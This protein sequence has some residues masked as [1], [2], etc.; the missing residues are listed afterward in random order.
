[1]NIK[2]YVGKSIWLRPTGNNAHRGCGTKVIEAV[3]VSAARVQCVIKIITDT[4]GGYEE[5]LR[6][7]PQHGEL[8]N[9][10][11]GGYA[12]YP[13]REALENYYTARLYA[14]AISEKYQ[15]RTDWQSVELDKLKQIAE[16]L[17]VSCGEGHAIESVTDI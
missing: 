4:G 11:G 8:S 3:V 13:T 12:T 17:G 15:Y 9:N 10:H 7:S 6:F 1:M 14:Q 2:D 5:K 16:L